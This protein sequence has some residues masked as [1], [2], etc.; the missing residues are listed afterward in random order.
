M[1]RK[2][3]RDAFWGM[4]FK[5][6]LWA[7]L[8]GIPVYLYFTILQ[9]ML[10]DVLQTYAQIQQAGAQMQQAGTQ[11]QVMSDAVPLQQLQGLLENIPSV[12]FSGNSQQ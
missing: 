7:V 8:L 12:D 6:V 10:A 9:P 2:M 5:I 1:L 4:V 11:L 3:R